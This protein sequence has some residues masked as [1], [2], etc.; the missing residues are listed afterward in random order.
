MESARCEVY[1]PPRRA[2]ASRRPGLSSP[3]GLS[4]IGMASLL[5]GGSR[6]TLRAGHCGETS[7]AIV[8]D[9]GGRPWLN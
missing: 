4:G 9:Y 3:H 7:S 6:S 8:I 5:S 2:V 1:S